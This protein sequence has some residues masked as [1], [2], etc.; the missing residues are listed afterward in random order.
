MLSTALCK[1]QQNIVDHDQYLWTEEQKT[2]LQI[3]VHVWGEV[4][5]PGQYVVPDGATV[6]DLISL[7]GGPNRFSN[8]SNVRLTREIIKSKKNKSYKIKEI[9]TI[10]FKTHLNKETIEPIY[11]LKPGD[12]IQVQRNTWFRFDT[13]LRILTQLAIIFQ[14]LYYTGIINP[15]D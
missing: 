10:N 7:A 8:L 1:A 5:R 14:G 9:R 12:V 4:N 11:I 2:K 3:I 13:L 15:K 6:L